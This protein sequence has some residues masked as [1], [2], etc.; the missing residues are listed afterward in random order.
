MLSQ[1][2]PLPQGEWINWYYTSCFTDHIARLT[3]ACMHLKVYEPSEI[4]HGCMTESLKSPTGKKTHSKLTLAWRSDIYRP[5]SLRLGLVI[6]IT[7]L[8]SFCQFQWPW[9]PFGITGK[10]G[11]GVGAVCFV[12]FC[13]V[14]FFFLVLNFQCKF[15][16]LG[17]G[18]SRLCSMPADQSAPSPAAL[19]PHLLLLVCKG[20]SQPQQTVCT[21]PARDPPRLLSATQPTAAR[22]GFAVSHVWWRLPVVLWRSEWL[23]AVWCPHQ[24]W[25]G[26][27]PQERQS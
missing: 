10:G 17:R 20:S 26:I 27:P 23:V 15:S 19:W 11:R 14:S 7:E 5:I 13:F 24:P 21:V 12:L 2:V 9:P 16:S 3:L 8:F 6:D 4:K 25:P 1:P 18:C 22:G